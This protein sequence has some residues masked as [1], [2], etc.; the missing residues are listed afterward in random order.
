MHHDV[1]ALRDFY[2][3]TSLGRAAQKAMRDRLRTCWS[4]TTGLSIAGFGFAAPCCA[5]SCPRPR[6]SPP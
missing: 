6:A 1:R 3:T 5:R 4:D 2:Y